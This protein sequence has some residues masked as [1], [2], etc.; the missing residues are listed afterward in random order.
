MSC[1]DGDDR[2]N[3][4]NDDGDEPPPPEPP[5]P[6]RNAVSLDDTQLAIQ[7]SAL[8]G[9]GTSTRCASCHAL[10]QERM[11]YWATLSDKATSECLT[12]LALPSAA[13]AQ[14]TVTCLRTG[15]RYKVARLGI[16]SAAAH[17]AWFAALFER[18][19]ASDR[20]A[21]LHDAAMP[22]G[23]TAPWTQAD[24][25]V[26]AEWFGRGLPGLST[27]ADA[28]GPVC[29]ASISPTLMTRV[30]E[31]A[32][33]GWRARNSDA[34]MLM[35]D[36]AAYPLASS[37]PAGE[38]WEVPGFGAIHL[39]EQLSYATRYETRSSADGRFV[40]HGSV[41]TSGA[42][43]IDLQRDVAVEVDAN[44]SP[45][46]TPDG[47]AFFF[48]TTSGRICA[49]GVLTS[50]PSEIMLNETGCSSAG[51]ALQQSF[52][53]L[54]LDGQVLALTGFF[55]SDNIGH[56][57]HLGD[58]SRDFGAGAGVIFTPFVYTGTDFISGGA[59][60]V[61]TPD[62]GDWSI[63]PSAAMAVA[64]VGGT[65]GYD[66]L[67]YAVHDVVRGASDITMP[68]IGRYCV[69]G[70][71]ATFSYDERWLAFH[72]T[73]SNTERDAVELGFTG[74]NDP[75]FADYVAKGTANL[76]V[77]DLMTGLSYRVTAMNAGQYAL[78]PHFRS[79]GWLYAIV[80][81]SNTNTEYV[82]ASEAARSVETS[83]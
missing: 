15:A 53:T 63:S 56:T 80:R 9:M 32:M 83:H 28:G 81:D 51:A 45:G 25:D 5:P 12:D 50:E 59:T 13:V 31:A 23:A 6:L 71:V 47:A 16:Y 79:D 4:D 52:A 34:G 74:K 77:V 76:Y 29:E 2:D 10:T 49:S 57:P 44:Y 40:A 60:P 35:Q 55:N 37:S 54:P 27:Y 67:G 58:S 1:D 66:P 68:E 46:F 62:R 17:L 39:L 30:T 38:G 24:F 14:Q 69:D 22:R 70:G 3:G 42:T 41:T 36:V 64:R 78:Y 82:I 75:G 72:H 18:S 11:A 20:S 48:Y 8:L 7:A 61:E 33:Q 43:I 19:G 73:I 65:A 21:F 26:V